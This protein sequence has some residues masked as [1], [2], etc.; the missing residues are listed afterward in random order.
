MWNKIRRSM[1]QTSKGQS[2]V[3]LTLVL[4]ILLLMLLGLMELGML[5][6]AY[7]VIVNANREAARFASRGTF[8]DEQVV[9]RAMV[10]VSG[11]LPVQISG[12]DAN[13]QIVITHFTIPAET[14]RAATYQTPYIT[15]TLNINSKIDPDVYVVK[16]K[17]ENDVFN[18]DLVTSQPNAIRT[19]QEI[20]FVEMFFTHDQVLKAPIVE[21][22]FPDPMLIYSMTMM[23]VGLGRS[24]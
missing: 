23:R 8:T 10:S 11:Q 7:L 14:N 5:L 16:L 6:R 17:Q 12:P 4:P 24:Y 18:D 3:E 13:T 20:V 1:N 21:W 9:Q 15:G 19:S 2:L 22:L